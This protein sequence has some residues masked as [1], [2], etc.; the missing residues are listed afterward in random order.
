M[1]WSCKANH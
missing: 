1:K